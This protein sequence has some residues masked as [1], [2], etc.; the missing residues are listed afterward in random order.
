VTSILAVTAVLK[1]GHLI[2]YV[3]AHGLLDPDEVERDWQMITTEAEAPITPVIML[4]GRRQR[5]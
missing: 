3:D 4:D 1:K 2:G 5:R